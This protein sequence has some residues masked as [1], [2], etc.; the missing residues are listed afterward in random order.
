MRYIVF[1]DI[2]G[3]GFSFDQFLIDIKRVDY[4]KLVFLGD[5]VGYYYD[6]AR[7]IDYCI[8]NN[9]L[10]LL[11]NHDSYFLKMIDGVLDEDLLVSKYG[12]SYIHAKKTISERGVEFLR[13]LNS[14]LVVD[15]PKMASVL[16]CHGS[17]LDFLDGRIYPNSDLN[18]F[19][20]AVT[21]FDFVVNGHTHHKMDRRLG[22]TCFLNPGSLGQQRDGL[23][24]SYLVLDTSRH[25]FFFGVVKY[26]ISKLESLIDEFDEGNEMLKSVLKRT[27]RG[28]D[29]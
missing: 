21:Q 9:V 11:G 29:C 4:D 24:C 8:S 22:R 18:I 13:T 17:P 10:C 7:I 19:Q 6:S 20:S 25:E 12:H 14:S 15:Q 3:N 28:V 1:S 5:F 27:P 23:G 16:F 26:D 2:H